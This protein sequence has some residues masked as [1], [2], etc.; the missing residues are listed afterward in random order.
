LEFARLGRISL[1]MGNSRMLWKQL[2]VNQGIAKA[3][4]RLQEKTG[5][6]FG[7]VQMETRQIHMIVP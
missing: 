3:E 1:E 2:P 4:G 5:A 7:F 6:G